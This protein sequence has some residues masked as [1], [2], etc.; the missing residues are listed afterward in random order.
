MK[1]R[2][3]QQALEDLGTAANLLDD[4]LR[5]A[6]R[7]TRELERELDREEGRRSRDSLDPV[8]LN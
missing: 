7:A 2:D 4:A 1:G 6:M 3:A 5:G 8:A